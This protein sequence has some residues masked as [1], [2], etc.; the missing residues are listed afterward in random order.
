VTKTSDVVEML[1]TDIGQLE[2]VVAGKTPDLGLQANG[3]M[4]I[5][6]LN[7]AIEALQAADQA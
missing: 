2:R 7:A 4:L 3:P 6:H 1:N 5:R